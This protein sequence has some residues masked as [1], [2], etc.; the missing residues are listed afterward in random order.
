MRKID[1]H[2]TTDISY[3][4][5]GQEPD[6]SKEGTVKPKQ[7]PQSINIKGFTSPHLY[8]RQTKYSNKLGFLYQ[9]IANY[10]ISYVNT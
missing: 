10:L 7:V 9:L 8:F 4:E 3:L 6:M 2:A 5:H 1:I